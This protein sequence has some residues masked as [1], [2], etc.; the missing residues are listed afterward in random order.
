MHPQEWYLCSGQRG[1]IVVKFAHSASVTQ[2]SRV[3]ILGMDLDTAHQAML[4][5]CPTYKLEE[6]WKQMLAQGQSSSPKEK[7]MV[8]MQ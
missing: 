7:K 3:R 5:R 6:D 4:W 8:P 2:G 1:G